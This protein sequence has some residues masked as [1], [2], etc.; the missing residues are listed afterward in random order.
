VLPALRR[1][2]EFSLGE[3][4]ALFTASYENYF[5]P[6]QI[7]EPTFAYMA[8][9]FDL[10]LHKSLVAVE[11]GQ[12][13]GIANLGRRRDR[14]WLG[15]IGVVPASRR[16]GV[17]ELLTRGL[18]DR[19]RGAGAREMVLEV[20][21][22]NT[23]AIALYEKLGFV[24]LR[25]LEIFTLPAAEQGGAPDDVQVEVEEAIRRIAAYRDQPE[26]WQRDDDTIANLARRYPPPR[27]L[28]TPGAAAVYRVERGRV[29]LL[30]AAGNPSGLRA[31]VEGLRRM[32]ILS[33]VN[34]PSGG[35]VAATMRVAGAEVSLRQL[36]MSL[37]L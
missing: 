16:T 35:S 31:A 26:P 27:G 36:E 1:A 28:V 37:A 5:V 7:D 14:T 18:L 17:G 6:F 15:G 4:A 2:S 8:D 22:E 10:D 3:L 12:P 13:I 33:A 29:S 32:G 24:R 25:E 21:A 30:Q 11:G 20:I 23:A 34:Y 9:V 19:A